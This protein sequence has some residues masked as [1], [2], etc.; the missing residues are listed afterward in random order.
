MKFG[1]DLSNKEVDSFLKSINLEIAPPSFDF[2]CQIISSILENTPFQNIYMLTREKIP[3]SIELIKSDMLTLKGGPCGH[4]NPFLGSLLEKLG[5]DVSLVP[6][7]MMQPNC[8]LGLLLFFQNKEYYIDC[9]DG[10]PYFNPIPIFKNSNYEGPSHAWRTSKK[11]N[12]LTIEYKNKKGDWFTNCTVSLQKVN[13]DFFEEVIHAHYTKSNYGPFQKGIRFAIYPNKH[14]RSLRDDT[15]TYVHGDKLIIQ[16]IDTYFELKKIHAEFL[17][18]YI[19]FDK[20]VE[21]YQYLIANNFI[22]KKIL[23]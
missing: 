17:I 8:H 13:F 5:Y 12:Q 11:D 22:D 10:K 14:I 1:V 3:P 16:K 19:K 9:G 2:L 15:F 18:K 7:S 21:S 6:G 20:L 4:I 23:S